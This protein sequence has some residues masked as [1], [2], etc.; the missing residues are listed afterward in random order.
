MSLPVK[1][2]GMGSAN[3]TAGAARRGS[4]LQ[5]SGYGRSVRATIPVPAGRPAERSGP[6]AATSS[7]YAGRRAAGHRANTSTVR[8]RRGS[9]GPQVGVRANAATDT[10]GWPARPARR[11]RCAPRRPAGGRDRRAR[12]PGDLPQRL[13]HRPR[14][15]IPERH[16][17][18]R[19]RMHPMEGPE[20]DLQRARDRRV[21]P[22]A[23]LRTRVTC[24]PSP[25]IPP[26]A[27]ARPPGNAHAGPQ[28]HT[29]ACPGTCTP[30]AYVV[31]SSPHGRDRRH[32]C[33]RRPTA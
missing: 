14:H 15:H 29:G 3:R 5:W 13:R 33:H 19:L 9:A 20:R 6:Q 21:R 25:R 4:G 31:W 22:G 27:R 11:R 10:A 30:A 8:C 12:R 1:T 28:A 7:P 23:Q 17:N 26:A 16:R 2:G 18:R 32:P 24:R